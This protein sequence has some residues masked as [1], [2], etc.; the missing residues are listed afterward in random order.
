[1]KI[2]INNKM[3]SK[4]RAMINGEMMM[5]EIRKKH[6]LIQECVIM[7][8]KITPLITYLLISKKG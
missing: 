4:R 1:M 2:K 8:K 5:M 3:K 7:L 6:N